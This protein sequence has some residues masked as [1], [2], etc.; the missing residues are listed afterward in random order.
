MSA[1]LIVT[2]TPGLLPGLAVVSEGAGAGGAGDSQPA[3][4]SMGQQ[5]PARLS[6]AAARGPTAWRAR[7]SPPALRATRA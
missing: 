1:G 5:A 3:A 4:E 2:V 6:L 7:R